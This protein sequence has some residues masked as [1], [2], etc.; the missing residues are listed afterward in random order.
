MN[1]CQEDDFFMRNNNEIKAELPHSVCACV[2]CIALRFSCNYFVRLIQGKR[3][4]KRDVQTILLIDLQNNLRH[5]LR[6]FMSTGAPRYL[7]VW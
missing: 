7:Q 3:V 2:F 1:F 4:R 5:Y 6:N